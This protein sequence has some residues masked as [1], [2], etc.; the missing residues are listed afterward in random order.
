MHSDDDDELFAGFTAPKGL[1]GQHQQQ[2]VANGS[3]S[4]K[5][6]MTGSGSGNGGGSPNATFAGRAQTQITTSKGVV[7]G[8]SH[9]THTTTGYDG[10]GGYKQVGG[11]NSRQTGV[12]GSSGSGARRG[13]Q[14][15][16]DDDDDFNCPDDF[17]DG[18]GGG[19]GY[20]DGDDEY[21]RDKVKNNNN[22][23]SSSSAVNQRDKS[24]GSGLGPAMAATPNIHTSKGTNNNSNNTNSNVMSNTANASTSRVVMKPGQ[25]PFVRAGGSNSRKPLPPQTTTT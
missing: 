21:M 11:S 24:G 14:D 19:G 22:T 4:K 17:D 16:D 15:D 1:P 12:A 20:G 23:T 25:R 18:G 13:D 8:G 7:S 6:G 3:S 10:K 9:Q 5:G 2:Y